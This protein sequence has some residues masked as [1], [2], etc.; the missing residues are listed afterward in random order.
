MNNFLL[1]IS[2]LVLIVIAFQGC[3]RNRNVES[4]DV[5][6]LKNFSA[7][8]DEIN[9]LLAVT[10]QFNIYKLDGSSIVP[11]N[12]K[13]DQKQLSELRIAMEKSKIIGVIRINNEIRFY[14]NLVNDKKIDYGYSYLINLPKNSVSSLDLIDCSGKK[15]IT[16]RSIENNWVA[17][18]FCSPN[19]I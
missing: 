7:H 1:K 4:I 11:E 2:W 9:N 10:R 13:I 15:N 6:I 19:E 3:D 14:S 17:F 16:Y 5:V 12:T 18:G 8:K